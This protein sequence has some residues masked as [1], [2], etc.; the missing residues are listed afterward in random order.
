M[1]KSPNEEAP[2]VTFWILKT[3]SHQSLTFSSRPLHVASALLQTGPL[4]AVES[5]YQRIVSELDGVR[6]C[7]LSDKVRLESVGLHSGSYGVVHKGVFS[8]VCTLRIFSAVGLLILPIS[9]SYVLR[10]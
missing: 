4:N 8:E 9:E 1:D 2:E 7:D 6:F 5:L 10:I 3:A